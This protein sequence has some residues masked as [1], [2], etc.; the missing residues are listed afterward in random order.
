VQKEARPNG[1]V[2]FALSPDRVGRLWPVQRGEP[3]AAGFGAADPRVAARQAGGGKAPAPG[4]SL[5]SGRCQV[6][7]KARREEYRSRLAK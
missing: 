2:F 3:P 5:R 7:R 4:G 1:L 6:A